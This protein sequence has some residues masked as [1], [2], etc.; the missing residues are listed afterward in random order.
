VLFCTGLSGLYFVV[1]GIQYW[2]PDYLQNIIGQDHDVVA[3]Y[4]SATSFTA[5]VGGVI[6]G[7]FV[8]QAFGGFTQKTS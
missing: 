3:Y 2:T 5:P 1:T 8:M 6:V 4:F 7:G